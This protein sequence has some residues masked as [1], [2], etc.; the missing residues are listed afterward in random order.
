MPNQK[1][2]LHLISQ[3]RGSRKI[4]FS[5]KFQM[6]RPKTGPKKR[7]KNRRDSNEQRDPARARHRQLLQ[8]K[9]PLCKLMEQSPE[10]RP[11]GRI[12]PLPSGSGRSAIPWGWT[13]RPIVRQILAEFFR[14]YRSRIG[15][16]SPK[17]SGTPGIRQCAVLYFTNYVYPKSRLAPI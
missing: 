12:L 11:D 6:L 8:E 15:K 2:I 17:P 3:A 13:I 4:P 9:P 10:Q 14:G 5:G 7:C 1:S 16:A